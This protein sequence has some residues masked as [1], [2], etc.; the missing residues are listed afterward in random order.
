MKSYLHAM[1]V[2]IG[3]CEQEI[4]IGMM[5]KT[6]DALGSLAKGCRSLPFLQIGNDCGAMGKSEFKVLDSACD[7]FQLLV[8][9]TKKFWKD[10]E[11]RV[12][13]EFEKR[14]KARVR[15]ETLIVYRTRFF[16]HNSA[17][18]MT[19]AVGLGPLHEGEAPRL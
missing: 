14:L 18:L 5:A 6:R 12:N 15:V 10:Y 1:L 9:Q 19:H 13:K 16:Q 7:I 8:P 2:F 4:N 3:N 11:R 17:P